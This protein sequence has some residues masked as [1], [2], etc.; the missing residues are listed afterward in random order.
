MST[1]V[2]RLRLILGTVVVIVLLPVGWLMIESDGTA[3]PQDG[4]IGASVTWALVMAVPAALLMWPRRMKEWLRAG[5]LLA[6]AAL[7]LGVLTWQAATPDHDRLARAYDDVDL[8]AGF[9]AKEREERGQIDCW[10]QECPS[11]VM[12]V[13]SDPKWSGE[14]RAERF[15]RAMAEE[16]WEVR[17][18][19]RPGVRFYLKDSRSVTLETEGPPGAP[20]GKGISEV[21]IEGR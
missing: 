17:E 3:S 13:R 14:E 16:A 2:T 5:A 1:T 6:V 10:V 11:I 9:V 19:N 18:G 12:T 4:W 7:F 15:D 20:L 8:P 21:T